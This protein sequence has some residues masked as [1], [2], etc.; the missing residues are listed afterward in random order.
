M[1]LVEALDS[2]TTL[3]HQF[4]S[5]FGSGSLDERLRRQIAE[6]QN[7][8][9]RT[10]YGGHLTATAIVTD[11]ACSSVLLIKNKALNRWLAPGGHCEYLEAPSAA[12]GREL[13]EE[14][15]LASAGMHRWHQANEFIPIDIDCHVIPANPAKKEPQHYHHDFRYVFVLED[16]QQDLQTDGKEI[17]G[18]K[19]ADL[20]LAAPD[21]P[22][23]IERLLQ[24]KQF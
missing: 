15:G 18:W 4:E 8:W 13:R 11:P 20:A 14:T 9:S 7:V 1:T 23:V 10:N 22:R 12:A 17:E 2:L 21:Y 6:G 19:Y 5:V 16:A 3:C 24:W